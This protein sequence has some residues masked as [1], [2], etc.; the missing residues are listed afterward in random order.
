MNQRGSSSTSGD[1]LEWAFS[2]LNENDKAAVAKGFSGAY[3]QARCGINQLSAQLQRSIE[4]CD[5]RHTSNVD[6]QGK[7]SNHRR[8]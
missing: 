2:E 3:K 5:A 7:N 8:P 4:N 6:G 1:S